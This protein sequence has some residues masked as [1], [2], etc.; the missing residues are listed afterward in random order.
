M[1]CGMGSWIQS[2]F[3]DTRMAGHAR[4]GREWHGM[5]CRVAASCC[6]TLLQDLQRAEERELCVGG[7]RQ[8]VRDR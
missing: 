8:R 5:A 4:Q 6:R 2:I 1:T 3:G 7:D